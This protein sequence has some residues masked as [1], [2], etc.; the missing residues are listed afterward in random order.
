MVLL[1]C[2]DVRKIFSGETL[3]SGVSMSV[4]SADKIGFVGINGAGKSTLFKIITGELDSDGGEIFKSKELNIGYLDQYALSGSD[5]SVWDEIASEFSEVA[6]IEDELNEIHFDIE[7]KSGSLDA[8]VK[9]QAELQ[10]RFAE[11]D[12]FYYKSKIRSALL[13]LGFSEDEFSLSVNSL[14]AARKRAYRWES[15]CWATR[16]CCFWTSRRTISILIPSSGW[17]IF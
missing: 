10:E 6:R 13:G 4:D 17:R 8:L 7:N 5:L 12:G 11:L 3:F 14:P 2:S 9:R 16:I 1:N 15:C